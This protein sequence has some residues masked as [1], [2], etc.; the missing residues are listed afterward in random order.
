M[1]VSGESMY[2]SHIMHLLFLFK[3]TNIKHEISGKVRGIFALYEQRKVRPQL[4]LVPQL[5]KL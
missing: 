1:G 4:F 3:Q 5:G 2:T